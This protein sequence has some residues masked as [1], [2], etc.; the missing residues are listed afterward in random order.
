MQSPHSVQFFDQ[1]FGRQVQAQDFALNPFEQLALPYLRGPVLDYGCGLG[2]LALVLARQGHVVEALDASPQAIA[3]LQHCAT[4]E[5]LALHS[6]QVD[7][8]EHQPA[9]PYAGIACIGLLMF[10]DCPC[11]QRQLQRLVDALAPGGVLAVNV[12]VQGTTYMDMFGGEDHCLFAPGELAARLGG[13]ELLAQQAHRFDAPGGTLKC[14]E[15]VLARRAPGR[16]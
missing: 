10:F 14:F 7:L 13:L 3:H 12:L 11:A 6:R 1:Q 9:G 15:T 5:G 4:Q 2:N 16:A 8:R